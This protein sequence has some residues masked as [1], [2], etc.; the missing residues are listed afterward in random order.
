MS[1]EAYDVLVVGGGIHGA[2]VAWEAA[3]RGLRVALVEAGDFNQ[4]TS[5]NSLRTLHGG[6]RHLQRLDWR[7]MRESIRERREWL[8]LAPELTR[9]LRFVLP[10]SARGSRRPTVLR[11]ALWA[12]DLL[13]SDRNHGLPPQQHLPDG[14]LLSRSEFAR[15][16]P[17]LSVKD[18]NGAA[19]WY[20]G[21]CLN[22]ER[23]Q[24]AVIGA[25][26]ACGAQVAN[27][28]KALKLKTEGRGTV[29]GA[30]VRDE[31][32]GAELDLQARLVINAAGPWI[33][34]WLGNSAPGELRSAQREPLF[35]ASSAFNLLV[36]K[37]PFEDA[38]GLTAP[39]RAAGAGQTSTYFVMPWNGYSLLGTRHL[40]CDPN[41]RSAEVSRE[42]VVDFLAD[43]NPLL[44]EHRLSGSDIHG[45]FSGLLP[46]AT[47]ASGPDVALERAPRIVDHS[48]DG[49]QGLFSIIGVKWTTARGVGERGAQI[50][51][52]VLGR[53]NRPLRPRALA[54]GMATLLP[55]I[56]PDPSLAAR[57]VPDQPVL[58]G[59]VVHAVREEMA[60]QLPDVVRRRTSLYLSAELD[61]SALNACAALMARELQWSR[62]EI[63]AQV[64]AAEAELAAFRGPSGA[65]L[66]G[67][68]PDPQRAA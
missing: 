35:R 13:S 3:L 54:M 36:R 49:L 6:L 56:D 8:R 57:V 9:P 40:R 55:A 53:A 37:L 45:V 24:L 15:R 59:H 29:R 27:Y 47:R 63:G 44:G 38:L 58:L 41:T 61:R 60:L 2:C 10:A 68:R 34:E 31:L 12:N 17:G 64:E 48:A 16:F 18:C 32:T 22:T 1:T 67:A 65:C 5:S 23:L 26:A 50:A 21:V 66:T 4:G 19:A 14:A 25:A 11:A 20:D 28:T 42:Q 52:R 46:E 43:V 30:R 7:L 51:C 39:N 33:E 62:R